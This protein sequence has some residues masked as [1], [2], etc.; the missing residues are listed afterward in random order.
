M[1]TSFVNLKMVTSFGICRPSSGQNIY[2][3]LNAGVYKVVFV[4]VIL[5]FRLQLPPGPPTFLYNGY[6][7]PFPGIKLPGW[8]ADHLSPPRVEVKEGSAKPLPPSVLSR[9]ATITLLRLTQQRSENVASPK[10]AV[11]IMAVMKSSDLTYNN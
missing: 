2:K 5:L 3:N 11:S 6:R 8:S 9:H 10:S 4:N 1:G 7:G